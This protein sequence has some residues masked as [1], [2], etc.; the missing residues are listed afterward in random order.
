MDPEISLIIFGNS[1][2]FIRETQEITYETIKKTSGLTA[3]TISK[4]ESGKNVNLLSIIKYC[5]SI[6]YDIVLSKNK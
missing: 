3:A 4:I 2:K 1:L 5:N 6:K